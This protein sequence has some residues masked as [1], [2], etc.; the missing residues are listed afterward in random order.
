V[1]TILIVLA[2]AFAVF[3]AAI[4]GS[5]VIIGGMRFV[6]GMRRVGG[7]A[8]RI[9][10]IVFLRQRLL[11]CGTLAKVEM[12]TGGFDAAIDRGVAVAFTSV[13]RHRVQQN[14]GHG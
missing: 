8:A 13:T 10:G 3:V 11:T 1:A 9:R 4:D 6:G 5:P 12:L 7:M 2:A 14:R